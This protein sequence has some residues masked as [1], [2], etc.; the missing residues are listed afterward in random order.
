MREAKAMEKNS[1]LLRMILIGSLKILFSLAAMLVI[2]VGYMSR[3]IRYDLMKFG[4]CILSATAVWIAISLVV[5]L[6][7]SY[8]P[9]RVDYLYYSRRAEEFGGRHKLWK[10]RNRAIFDAVLLVVVYVLYVY[11]P[12]KF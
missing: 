8:S 5:T 4:W 11:F 12:P 2:L 3:P 9:T 6:K 7:R 10:E 1:R